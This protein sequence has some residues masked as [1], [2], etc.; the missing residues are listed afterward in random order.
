MSSESGDAIVASEGKFVTTSQACPVD[1]RHC[2]LREAF[3]FVEHFFATVAF[4]N[5]LLWISD[6]IDFFNVGP[7]DKN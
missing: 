1:N 6:R 2:Y 3:K 5:G 4:F 7:S